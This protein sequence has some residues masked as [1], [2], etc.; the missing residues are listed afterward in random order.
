MDGDDTVEDRHAAA[1]LGDS[2]Y[3]KI[4]LRR[5]SLFKQSIPRTLAVQ[6]FI[7]TALALV[8][9][10]ALSQPE[11][12]RALLG[13]DVLAATPRF[14]FLGAYATAIELVGVVGLGYVAYR[15]LTTDD[16]LSEREVHDLLAL[17]DAVT[18]VSIVTGGAAVAVVDA[19]FLLGLAGNPLVD[20]FQALVGR[21][22]FEPG[23]IPVTVIGVAI[24]A[25][26]LAAVAF[27]LGRLLQ[28]RLPY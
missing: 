12:T 9:P 21:N 2:R 19:F 24:A 15:R 13:S 11:S 8:A 7:L 6:G 18:H 25:A 17:E 1:L 14:L 4:K 23:L 3:E 28:D 5:Y 10:L 26:V 27:G 20:R 16:V 22:P